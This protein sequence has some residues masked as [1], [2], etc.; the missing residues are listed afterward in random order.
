VKIYLMTDL[1]GVAGVQN[2]D[3]T[4]PG[5]PYYAVGRELLTRE[6]N[7]AAEGLLAGGASEIV[8]SDAHGPGAIDIQILDPH[9]EIQRGWPDEMWPLGL[10]SSFDAVVWVGQHAKACSPYGHLCHT[11]S[12]DYIDESVNGISIGEFGE[13]ALCAAELGVRAIFG[14]G[15]EAFTKEA[16]A[17]VPGIETVAV[18]RGLRGGPTEDLDVEHYGR[19]VS[20]ARHLHPV[21]AREL[22]RE[23]AERAA[24]RA[25]AD[26]EYG[27]VPPLE[28]PYKRVIKLRRS[29][30]RQYPTVMRVSHPTSFI[31]VMNKWG[32]ERPLAG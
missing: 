29:E 1:E 10:D 23:G 31:G 12:L 2:W 8:V 26:Q 3:W 28:P 19:Q 32:K 27:V 13:L 25:A 17:L 20:S 7:A 4:G 6:V 14:S 18:K 16:Q 11:Q 9:V 30:R 21:K 15:D 5:K 22:I 24:A